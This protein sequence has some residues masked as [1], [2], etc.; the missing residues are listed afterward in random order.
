MAAIIPKQIVHTEEN[1]NRR[2]QGIGSQAYTNMFLW[3][4]G[5]YLVI[6]CSDCAPGLSLLGAGRLHIGNSGRQ[7]DG[8][9]LDG[10]SDQCNVQTEGRQGFS[11]DRGLQKKKQDAL[12]HPDILSSASSQSVAVQSL[13]SG[14]SYFS[15]Q[16][17][18]Q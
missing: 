1:G 14:S 13:F 6:S 2:V 15:V 5:D 7:I 18:T 12:S 4:H 10:V 16:S 11:R 8:I 17:E 3:L 9:C